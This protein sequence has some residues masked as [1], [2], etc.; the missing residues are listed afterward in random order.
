MNLESYVRGRWQPGTGDAV[1]LR[2]ATTGEPVA[3]ASSGGIDF[4]GTL[5]HARAAGG[6]AL[7]RMTFHERAALLKTLA[8]HLTVHKESFYELSYATGATRS[9]SWIDID[10]GIGTLFAYASRGRRELP[11]GH[12]YL[13][14]GVE[15][16]SKTGSFVGQHV[17]LPLEGAAVH[18]NAFNF[19][20]WGMLEKF[21]PAL[22]A[23]VPSI[24]KPATSTAYL[25]ERVVRSIVDS[26][27]L[28]EG[29]LQLICGGVGDL[30]EHLSCQDIVSFTGSAST[31]ARR[32][33]NASSSRRAPR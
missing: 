13:D 12:V 18:I 9:D 11:N 29:V 17:C 2:D 14:G 32:C 6:P 31:A 25:T 24:V 10:G 23:G 4:Q 15:P 5:E 7:R 19:P 27:L 8:Q 26:G 1:T 33:V 16:L 3:V 30:F 22:L 20:V 28:P 21:A